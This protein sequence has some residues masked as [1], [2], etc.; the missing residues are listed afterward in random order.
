[1]IH[2][3]TRPALPAP[4]EPPAI[5]FEAVLEV[6]AGSPLGKSVAWLEPPAGLAQPGEQ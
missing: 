5:I 4:Y 1:M 3:E 2:A 6:R